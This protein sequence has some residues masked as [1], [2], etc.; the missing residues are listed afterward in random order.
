[1]PSLSFSIP[2]HSCRLLS[3]LAPT[4]RMPPA[5]PSQSSTPSLLAHLPRSIASILV[6]IWL[7]L[8][9]LLHR[10]HQLSP[11]TDA[12]LHLAAF[13][14]EAAAIA[15]IHT[16]SLV[17]VPIDVGTKAPYSAAEGTGC[18]V[19]I[20][21]PQI[22][23]PSQ[24]SPVHR[25]HTHIDSPALL[26]KTIGLGLATAQDTALFPMAHSSSGGTEEEGESGWGVACVTHTWEQRVGVTSPGLYI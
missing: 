25:R 17:G 3:R 23:A 1:M 15:A 5:P 24:L 21:E 2:H 26:S 9:W 13:I 4:T 14:C 12:T 20:V 7:R 19:I 18:F 6:Q 10:H 11:T 16:L 8:R 22:A